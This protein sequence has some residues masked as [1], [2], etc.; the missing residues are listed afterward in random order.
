MLP[1]CYI[2][3]TTTK[4]K[5]K[6]VS[7]VASITQDMHFCPSLIRYAEKYGVTNAAIKYKTNRQ[8][9]YRWRFVEAFEEHSTYSSAMF[10]EH[11][12]KAFPFPVECVQTDNGAEF[13]NRF[14]LT[15]TS[16]PCSRCI[17]RTTASVTS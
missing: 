4:S 17:Y 16:P 15:V 5:P 1:L 14:R 13:T 10:L 8:Y 3:V 12:L 11:L 7:A 2:L 9:I 6:E